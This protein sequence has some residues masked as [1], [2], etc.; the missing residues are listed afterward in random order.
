MKSGVVRPDAEAEFL[1]PERCAI[2]EAWNDNSDASIARA[3]VEP[4]VKL[5]SIA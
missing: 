3:R 4:G 5:N 2:L 1:T